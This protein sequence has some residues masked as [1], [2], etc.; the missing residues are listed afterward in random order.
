MIKTKVPRIKEL[1][2]DVGIAVSLDGLREVHDKV[3]GIKGSFEKFNQTVLILKELT[4][5]SIS[6]GLTISKYN[7]RQIGKV[8]E[9]LNNLNIEFSCFLPD[10]SSYYF[11]NYGQRK[12]LLNKKIIKS[13]ITSLR[14]FPDH[15]YMDNLR[16]FFKISYLPKHQ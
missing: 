1:C 13:T 10:E 16:K 6:S 11:E 8:A 15:Y 2:P 5:K 3:R 7:Y 4:I 14:Q 12:F 9:L